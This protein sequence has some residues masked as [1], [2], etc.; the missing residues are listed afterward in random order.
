VDDAS[1]SLEL[2]GGWTTAQKAHFDDGGLYDQIIAA[3][4]KR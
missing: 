2:Y 1:P 4:G 3:T